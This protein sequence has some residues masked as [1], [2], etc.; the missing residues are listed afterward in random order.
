MTDKEIKQIFANSIDVQKTADRL[1]E[2]TGRRFI[3]EEVEKNDRDSYTSGAYSDPEDDD[4]AEETPEQRRARCRRL[5]AEADERERRRNAASKRKAALTMDDLTGVVAKVCATADTITVNKLAVAEVAEGASLFSSFER[6]AMLTA[7]AKVS[8]RGGGSDDQKASRFL[9]DPD[10][11]LLLRWSLLHANPS[12]AKRD[13]LFDDVVAKNR[14]P[15]AAPAIGGQRVYPR[16]TGAAL[17]VNNPTEAE[18]LRYAEIK[19]QMQTGRWQ[20][21]E[22]AARYVDGLQAELDRMG[23]AKQQRARPGTLERV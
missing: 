16:L 9:Q 8:D 6:S 15:G 3:V 18:K 7:I 4:E 5:L 22:E 23:R 19:R 13:T 21:V 11:R 17:P 10:N 14:A 12:I 2:L 20:S 1:Y